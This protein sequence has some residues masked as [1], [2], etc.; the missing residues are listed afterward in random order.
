MDFC[1]HCPNHPRKPNFASCQD[2][3]SVQSRFQKRGRGLCASAHLDGV[4]HEV[5]LTAPY[6]SLPVVYGLLEL[7]ADT[8]WVKINR[9]WLGEGNQLAAAQTPD[10]SDIQQAV[11]KGGLWN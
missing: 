4:Q 3:Q 7:D 2:L 5:D 10:S 6:D 9:T 11:C 8:Q 1:W